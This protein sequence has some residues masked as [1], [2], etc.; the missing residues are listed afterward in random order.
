MATAEAVQPH[1]DHDDHGHDH[2][3]W[4]A[5][6]FETPEQQFDAGKLGIWLFLAQEV[7]FFTGLFVAYAVYRMNNPDV[8]TDAA[9]YLNP[10]LGALNT[11][12]LLASSLAIAW[13]VRA[14]QKNQ[15]ELLLWLHVFTLAC[16][17]LFMGVKVVEY[18]YKFD[19]GLYWAGSY[20]PTHLVE[21]EGLHAQLLTPF[22]WSA[23]IGGLTSVGGYFMY[24]LNS[25][26]GALVATI[27]WGLIAV[28]FS[29]ALSGPCTDTVQKRQISAAAEQLS[30]STS[31]FYELTNIEPSDEVSS[32]LRTVIES[33]GSEGL[34][35]FR[36][37]VMGEDTK[38]LD[39]LRASLAES[40]PETAAA[41]DTIAGLKLP[42]PPAEDDA[43][44]MD[45]DP[46]AEDDADALDSDPQ[47]ENDTDALDS[48]PQA[49]DDANA[50]DSDPQAENDTDALDSD[51]QAEDDAN[52]LD[53]DPQAEDD[54][55][56]L[57]S[58]PRAEDDA[59]ALD[60]DPQAEDDADALDSDPRAE[61]VTTVTTASR[62]HSAIWSDGMKSFASIS[63]T[64][65]LTAAAAWLMWL[66]VGCFRGDRKA[67]GAV[68][69]GLGLCI[70]GM[71]AGIVIARGIQAGHGEGHGEGHGDSH[72]V[73]HADEHGAEHHDAEHHEEGD[74][75]HQ[76]HA[77][78]EHAPGE[79]AAEPTAV[80]SEPALAKLTPEQLVA[81]AGGVTMG[82]F[83]SIYFAMTGVH[84][85]HIF[86]GIAV[87]AWI[88][89][90]IARGDFSPE[91]YGPVEFVGL[92]WHLVDLVWI[93]LFPLLYLIH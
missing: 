21:R 37:I 27:G 62:M 40:H 86:A 42:E 25:S 85:L 50:L 13:G 51:P 6:H 71:A 76:D 53:S 54:A 79:S 56:A 74:H 46:R 12:V 70:V 8:F 45:S 93:Y 35:V 7:L 66:F 81:E 57:D 39:A 72:A 64:A 23:V 4:L 14:A 47:A 44:A 55:N 34:S 69:V 65:V 48:D 77:D 2:P 38:R 68:S 63:L 43:D 20:A 5:H 41:I 29:S 10:T 84:A 75:A 31:A 15:Q 59:D 22:L 32:A 82:N 36:S 92:Y 9:K 90:R 67:W 73:A 11:I 89:G 18:S 16:A 1:A 24:R 87:I 28:V 61:I 30:T 17:G 3:D 83:F 80:A 33:E 49:E 60:S 19:E 52:A 26:G 88:I 78:E 91:F 58:D